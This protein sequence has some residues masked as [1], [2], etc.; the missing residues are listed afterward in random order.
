[1]V[2]KPAFGI[3]TPWAYGRLA[4]GAPGSYMPM[5]EAEA[6]LAAWIGNGEARAED[7][8]FNSMERV[9]FA[10][11][12]ALP[13]L[14]EQLRREFALEPR[15]SGSG[16]ACFAFLSDDAPVATIAKAV[17]EAWGDTSFIVETRIA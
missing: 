9:A 15:M 8:L 3:A 16:S 4:S 6:R 7:L 11:F 1:M 2:F 5:A 14:L 13:T 10:K 17:R 12:I